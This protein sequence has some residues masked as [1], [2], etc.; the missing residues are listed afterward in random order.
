MKFD[1]D[2]ILIQPAAIS[3][4]ESRKQVDVFYDN[5]YLPLFTAP[6]DTVID[7]GNYSLFQQFHTL[8]QVSYVDL[9]QGVHE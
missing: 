6:M 7:D 5:G 1:F 8:H 4:I 9:F 3:R 2:D